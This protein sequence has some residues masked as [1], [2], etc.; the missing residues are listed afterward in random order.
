MLNFLLS[1][2]QILNAGNTIT[3]FSLLLYALTFNL[4]SRVARA[5]AILFSCVTMVYFGDVLASTTYGT[6]E[7]GMMLQLQWVGISF[8]PAA[9]LHLSDTLLEATGRPSRGRRRFAVGLSYALGAVTLLLVTFTDVITSGPVTAGL[10]TFLAPGWLFPVF[11]LFFVFDLTFS[12]L[13]FWRALRRSLS[14]S[15]RRRISYLMI[16]SLGP[17]FGSFPFLMVGG[18]ALGEQSLLFWSVVVVINALASVQM[19]QMS[20]AVAY[21]GSAAPDRVVKSRL[22]QWILRGPVVGSSVLAVM[23]VVD[24]LEDLLGIEGNYIVSFSMVATLL[25]LQYVIT[26]IRPP[27]ER[28]LFY[29]RDREEIIRLQLLEERLLTSG[30]LHQF[31][32]AVLNAACDIVRARSGFLAIVGSEGLELEVAVG[33]ED[34]LRDRREL[35]PLLIT[36]NLKTFEYLGPIFEW[37]IYW[38]IP[39]RLEDDEDKVVG[40]VGLAARSE[41]PDFTGEEELRLCALMGQAVV[42]LTDQLLQREVFQAVDRLMP[43]VD[44]IQRVRASA[45]YAD[46]EALSRSMQQLSSEEEFVTL[47]RDALGHYWGGPRLTDSPLLELRIVRDAESGEDHS[48]VNALRA[49]LRRAIERTRPEGERRFTAEWMLY[50]ILEMKFLQGKKVREIALRLS[51]SEADLYRKQRVAIEAVAQTIAAMERDAVTEQ[52]EN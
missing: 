49:V 44:A 41:V 4:K 10:T 51:M 16:G 23:I 15:S 39:L 31:F 48:P 1:L 8:V 42:A 3:A 35:P 13:N 50:N 18:S 43:K 29:G 20:Y 24:R 14:S 40:I 36:N 11:V 37:D 38:L 30:D 27:L 33:S 34:P 9:F 6:A 45:S 52:K 7:V 12:G 2:N 19:V 22:F 28:W 25:L 5:L 21:F 26:L 47:V 46:A 17:L 32:E